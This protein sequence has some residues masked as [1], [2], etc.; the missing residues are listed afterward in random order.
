MGATGPLGHSDRWAY[1]EALCVLTRGCRCGQHPER[2]LRS[3][4]G[5]DAAGTRLTGGAVGATAVVGAFL[6]SRVVCWTGW[7][8]AG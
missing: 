3:V 4:I 1:V 7:S 8:C 6:H 2:D 5:C